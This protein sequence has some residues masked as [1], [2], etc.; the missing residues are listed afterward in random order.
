[1]PLPTRILDLGNDEAPGIRLVVPDEGAVGKYAALSYCWGRSNHFLL[2]ATTME[3]L[4][5]GF[6]LRQLPQ[7]LQDAVKV[8]RQIGIRYLWID[9]LCIIQGKDIEA[10]ND[11]NA[12]VAKMDTVY[13]NAALT[14]SAASAQNASGGLFR[15]SHCDLP[16]LKSWTSAGREEVVLWARATWRNYAPGFKS[17]PVNSRAWALQEDLLSTRVLFYTSFG[18]L[19]KCNEEITWV[20]SGESRGR[21]LTARAKTETETNFDNVRFRTN[22]SRY[23][24]SI[25]KDGHL[26]AK[27]WGQDL[28][29]YTARNLTNPH[30]KLPALAA[31][32]QRYSR[33]T[34]T[35]YLAGLWKSTFRQDLLWRHPPGY[36]LIT[37]S[38]EG[39]PMRG[40]EYRAPSWSWAAVDGV[41]TNYWTGRTLESTE[42]QWLAEVTTYPTPVLVDPRNPFGG[43]VEMSVQLQMQGPMEA[44]AVRE[45]PK[46]NSLVSIRSAKVRPGT[47]VLYLDDFTQTAIWRGRETESLFC[48]HI[49]ALSDSLG[50]TSYAL[51]LLRVHEQPDTYVRIGQAEFSTESTSTASHADDMATLGIQT[52]TIL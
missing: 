18:L 37:V 34:G 43:V 20:Y 17:E 1:M 14:I 41:V 9:A 3:D 44:F 27:S 50:Q 52:V 5:N 47:G 12:E 32:A 51:A 21:N 28:E 38:D 42:Y 49:F 10:I 46:R 36:S 22:T 13:S 40:E 7:T 2:T 29:L 23:M 6:P 35:E 33:F 25:L 8:T 31:V 30:D 45:Y 19:W 39:N 48:L 24:H 4:K 16:F 11:W 26:K 15:G